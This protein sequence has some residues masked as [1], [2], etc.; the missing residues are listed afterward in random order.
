VAGNIVAAWIV[1]LPAAAAIGAVTY[2]VT[3]LFGTGAAGP[4]VVSVLM[5]LGSALLFSRRAKH[6]PAPAPA[7]ATAEA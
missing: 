3:R 2:A 5:I 1:T 6:G 4:L 7:R